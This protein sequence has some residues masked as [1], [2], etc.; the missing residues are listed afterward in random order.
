LF[1]QPEKAGGYIAPV[2]RVF[3]MV[4]GGATAQIEDSHDQPDGQDDGDAAYSQNDQDSKAFHEGLRTR[5]GGE[6][7]AAMPEDS[8]TSRDRNMRP[9]P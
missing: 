6:W 1:F 5:L 8:I 4:G 9:R 3:L 2:L 7:L